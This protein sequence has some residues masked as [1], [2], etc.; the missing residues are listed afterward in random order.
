M[1]GLFKISLI[2]ILLF[3][4]GVTT[5]KAQSGDVI[6]N[7]YPEEKAEIL[8]TWGEIVESVQEGNVDKLISFHAYGPKFTEF[9]QGAPRNGGEENEAFEREVFGSVTEAVRMDANDMKVAVYYG[10]VAVVTFHS[11]FH[12]RFEENVAVINDQISLV[13]VKTEDGEWKIVH[14]HHSPLN[15]E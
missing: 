2:C 9:K 13:F 8:E 14:E 1:N 12:L 10:N 6:T 7:E 4:W 3:G 15:V 11:D 5:I